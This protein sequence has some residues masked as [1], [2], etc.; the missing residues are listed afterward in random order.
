[1]GLRD[2]EEVLRAQPEA[3]LRLPKNLPSS[4]G[5][6]RSYISLGKDLSYLYHGR[7]ILW[8]KET[9]SPSLTT[10][11]RLELPM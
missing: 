3:L 8:Q 9:T 10:I 7:A 4:R 2:A 1:M 5:E 6:I 11:S